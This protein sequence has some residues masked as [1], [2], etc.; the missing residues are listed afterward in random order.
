[1]VTTFDDPSPGDRSDAEFR[2]HQILAF[3]ELVSVGK[4]PGETN[5]EELATLRDE[6]FMVL[7]SEP[8]DISHAETLTAYAALLL[9]GPTTL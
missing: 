4:E 1:M 6:V 5:G 3:W 7:A 9:A 8:P 2:W